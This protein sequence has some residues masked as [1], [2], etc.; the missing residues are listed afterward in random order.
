M[1]RI[2]PIWALIVA[3]AL[4]V[5]LGGCAPKQ[6]PPEEPTVSKD[7]GLA[8]ALW[9][10]CQECNIDTVKQLIAAGA[11]LNSPT[12]VYGTTPLMETVRSYDNKCPADI[13]V[14]LIEAG[15]DINRRDKRGYTALHYSA[16][17]NCGTAHINATR[18]L[19]ENGADP[20]ILN[21]QK[22]TPLELATEARCA[23]KVDLLVEHIKSY[24]MK[25]DAV[26]PDPTKQL[27]PP[28][29]PQT[30]EGGVPPAQ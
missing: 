13:A 18:A 28:A 14:L 24:R 8:N 25:L 19:L 22:R 4:V 15:A 6:T 7:Y 21:Q 30:Q 9:S 26:I 12:G 17:Y 23:D 20:G 5:G 27:T 3:L 16:K 1:I 11:D 10:A 2:N 29:A